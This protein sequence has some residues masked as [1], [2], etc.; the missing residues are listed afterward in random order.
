MS[1]KFFLNES[2][3]NPERAK[4]H[5]RIIVNRQKAE[6]ATNC[7]IP[8]NEWD[9]SKQRSQTSQQVNL[10]L[11]K[12]ENKVLQLKNILEYEERPISARILKDMLTD[13]E[14]L[15]TT[16]L[17][18]YQKFID[19]TSENPELSPET[20]SLYK[21]T[22]G[23][24]QRFTK[25]TYKAP[26]VPIKQ[27]DYNFVI[28]LDQYLLK[29]GLKRN[30]VNKHHSR[31]RTLIHRALYEG[32]LEKNPYQNFQLKDE[33]V[34]R[35]A[36]SK[37]ELQQLVNHGLGDNES[38]QKVRDI[39]VFSCYTGLRYQDAQNLG[40]KDIH[41]KEN[42]KHYICIEQHKTGEQLEI[43]VLAPA[44]AIIDRY[45][46]DERKITGKILPKFSNQK[47]NAYLKVVAD[48]VGIKKTL[49]HH[50]AR[51]TCAT[52]VL[53]ANNV[54]LKAV[55]KWLGHTN[56]KQT[57]KYAKITVDYL[58]DIADSLEGKI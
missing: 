8:V 25:E 38:L 26:D 48:L 30:T 10:E 2:K 29:K 14:K 16:L 46:K 3:N 23:Y 43:P 57:E 1:L 27:L 50:V 54:S 55:S 37:K 22:F 5:L 19:H 47:I 6:I 33:K 18:F 11:N 51:H 24:V 49:T 52:T 36:L 41:L 17:S 42:G 45:D 31:F 40:S 35:E 58:G 32:Q 28:R 21:Q 44:Q 13:R 7:S 34:N 9:E 56:I 12:L 53:L 15:N 20:I 4:I 39:F